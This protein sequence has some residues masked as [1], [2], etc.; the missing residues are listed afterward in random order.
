MSR[1]LPRF[2]T[3]QIGPL[4]ELLKKLSTLKV[5]IANIVLFRVVVDANYVVQSL[6]YRVHHRDRG[7][8]ALEEMVK[9]TVIDVFAPRWLDMLLG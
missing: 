1:Q 5:L 6:I 4:R 7:A 3:A 2:D 8:T 9:A